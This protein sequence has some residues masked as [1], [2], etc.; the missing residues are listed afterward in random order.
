MTSDYFEGEEMEDSAEELAAKI[1]RELINLDSP[2]D[3]LQYEEG[4][5]ALRTLHPGQDAAASHIAA[6][7]EALRL[8]QEG[9]G[10]E[11]TEALAYLSKWLETSR[12]LASHI[13]AGERPGPRD[14]IV[15]GW[16]PAGRV[17]IISGKGGI[18]KSSLSVQLG[19]AVASGADPQN[20]SAWVQGS[21]R[22]LALGPKIVGNGVPVVFASWEDEPDEFW[23]RLSDLSGS[24]S[25]WVTPEHMKNLHVVDAVELGPLWAPGE[26]RHIATIASL[27]QAGERV[28]RKAEHENARLLILDPL[29]AVYAADENARGLVRAFV[30]DWDGWGRKN[31]CAVVILAHPPKSGAATSGSTDWEGATR[32]VI[33]L[34]WELKREPGSN[35]GSPPLMGYKLGH[36]KGNYGPAQL[37]Y[38][39]GWDFR[40]G[41]RRFKVV[42]AW[43]W[44]DEGPITGPTFAEAQSNG[45]AQSGFDLFA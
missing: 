22:E 34:T 35:R 36:E 39:L 30:A 2:F 3:E 17:S 27:T 40:G 26:E 16:I 31:D 19:A 23:R 14:W 4:I 29:A 20:P 37:G 28:R 33:T 11:G 12:L 8:A 25:P 42:G 32:S 10:R 6:L 7:L 18:G 41:G 38:E 44:G 9:N 45:G 5:Q 1:L 13:W 24:A 43:T 15:E 21:N